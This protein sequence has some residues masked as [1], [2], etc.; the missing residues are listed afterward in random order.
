MFNVYN[1]ILAGGFGLFVLLDA[2]MPARAYPSTRWWKLRGVTSA[3][4]YIVLAS[5]S[6]YLWM[7]WMGGLTLIDSTA[8]PLLV[9]VPLGYAVL[10][11]L[12]YAWHRALHKFNV[13]WRVFHQMHHSA[14]SVDIYGALYFHPLDAIGFTFSSS[15]ALTVVFGVEPFAAGVVGVM[16][17]V[18]SLFSHAN[19]KTPRW[20]GFIIARP[21]VHALHHERGRHARNYGELMIWDMIFGTYENPRRW[22]GQVGF[23]DGASTRILEM[24]MF[25]D[26]SKP[27][28]RVVEPESLE[29][30][31]VKRAA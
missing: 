28:I 5:Y 21:E 30:V 8:L 31:P 29:A 16:A 14:E 17:G 7:N 4:L 3:A 15:F 2:I 1:Y 18:I 24:L 22:D 6:P 23:Y 19:L 27:R 25:R 13:L 10:Q 9:A 12:Q 26:V 11:L 20:L